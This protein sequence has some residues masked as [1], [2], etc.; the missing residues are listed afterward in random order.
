MLCVKCEIEMRV[1]AIGVLVDDM[2]FNPP[3]TRRTFYADMYEC[4]LCGARVVTGFS[5]P[6]YDASTIVCNKTTAGIVVRDF[7]SVKAKNAYYAID[8]DR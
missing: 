3:E 2:A 7:E 4:K 8:G 5:E 6:E 1:A